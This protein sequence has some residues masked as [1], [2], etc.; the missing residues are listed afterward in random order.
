MPYTR[1]QLAQ[2][3]QQAQLQLFSQPAIPPPS[4]NFDFDFLMTADKTAI[5]SGLNNFSNLGDYSHTIRSLGEESL[6]GFIRKLVYQA[7]Y[8]VVLKSSVRDDTDS[9]VYEYL[10]GQC[11]NHF[12]KYYPFFSYTFAAC[13][14]KNEAAWTQMKNAPGG[15]IAAYIDVMTLGD[16]NAFI[17]NGCANN[18]ISCLLTQYVPMSGNILDIV[19]SFSPTLD[20]T[21]DTKVKVLNKKQLEA[22]CKKIG[23]MVSPKAKKQDFI[24]KLQSYYNKLIYPA[25][26]VGI[27][28][29][30]T[31]FFHMTY[32]MLSSLQNFLTHYDLH[33][34]NVAV[35]KVPDGKAV[36]V[37]YYKGGNNVLQFKTAL[38]PVVIDY[39]RCFVDC[40]ALGGLKS[41]DVITSVCRQDSSS[42]GP[43]INSCGNDRGYSFSPE[44]DSKTNTFAE[45]DEDSYFINYTKRNK[46]HDLRFLRYFA[47][48]ID[49]SQVN[50]PLVG[51]FGRIESSSTPFGLPEMAS[52][53]DGMVRNVDDALAQLTA[54]LQMPGFTTGFE[55]LQEYGTVHINTDLRA[56]FAFV[57]N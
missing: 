50:H 17:A 42:G 36:T 9:L 37:I 54:I 10:V 43:C 55:G 33:A 5:I 13:Q 40:T 30:I 27:L 41:S 16:V 22:E 31:L 47:S 2:Q 29:Q 23:M 14:Y 28:N 38:I 26:H 21:F 48:S 39:G 34:G 12:S 3:A 45:T 6:N 49:F 32:T 20:P 52:L 1:G 8:N 35:V 7:G 15:S 57:K 25:S 46:S 4:A 11:I 56:P 19:K 44:Y 53:P 51:L 18:K 24:D